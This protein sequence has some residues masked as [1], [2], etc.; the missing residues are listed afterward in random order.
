LVKDL[1]IFQFLSYFTHLI[2]TLFKMSV[3]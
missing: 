3:K 2:I 1:E